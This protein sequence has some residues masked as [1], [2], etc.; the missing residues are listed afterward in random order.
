M[1][2]ILFIKIVNPLQLDFVLFFI[3]QAF[4]IHQPNKR[5]K[6]KKLKV[7]ATFLAIECS[8]SL[9]LNRYVI[10]YVIQFSVDSR[11]DRS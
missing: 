7:E 9:T 3:W 11:R 6:K 8:S 2:Y 1:L 4:C 5:R 10:R